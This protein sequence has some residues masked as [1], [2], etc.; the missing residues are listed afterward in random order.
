[1]PERI[2]PSES[3]NPRGP[4][5]ADFA[6]GPA[7]D[8]VDPELLALPDPPRRERTFTV[9]LLAVTALA[10]AAMVL[11]LRFDAAYAFRSATPTDI[12]DLRTAPAAALEPNKLVHAEGM[13]G[14]AGAIRY[15]HAF[16]GDTYRV[17]PVAGRRDVWVEVRLPAG[18]E[19]ARYVPKSSFTGRLV[20]LDSAGP[21]HRGLAA[22]VAAITGEA[23]PEGAWLL[24]DGEQPEGAK[25][26]VALL[27]LF[28]GF[29]LWNAVAI[30]RL[31]RRV[32]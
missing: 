9:L 15:E 5:S 2:V 4:S 16:E 27:A 17:S 1:L 28:A 20:R 10:S 13:L 25:W 6:E 23:V 3:M 14:A 32:G 7:R 22:S 21:R 11:A 30:A 8:A 12:G 18:A 26:A 31:V 24:V 29:A 19:S